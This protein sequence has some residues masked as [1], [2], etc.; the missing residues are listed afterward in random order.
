MTYER[1]APMRTLCTKIQQETRTRL[2]HHAASS[3]EMAS[4][5][6]G[7]MHL[8]DALPGAQTPNHREPYDLRND[9]VSVGEV[10]KIGFG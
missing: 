4:R 6:A 2:D 1:F 7:G 5:T 9:H 8:R 3:S 10:E